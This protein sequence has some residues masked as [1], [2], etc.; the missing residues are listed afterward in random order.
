MR[1][2]YN[3]DDYRQLINRIRQIIPGVSIATDIIVGFPGETE[4]HFQ[5]TYDLLAELKLD[6][7]HIA[8]YSARPL[9]VATRTMEDN[10]PYEIKEY[11]RKTLDDLQSAIV[12][13]INAQYLGTVVDVLVE[14]RQERKNRWFG[15]TITDRLVY[16][17]S[18]DFLLGQVVHVGITWAGPWS[19]IGE[20][21]YIPTR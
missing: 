13:E 1:R 21:R 17:E 12:T 15:R 4:S 11:R 7:A 14:G 8:R 5:Q 19:L 20:L 9:T 6:K 16:F 10:L 3:R 18:A 2:G